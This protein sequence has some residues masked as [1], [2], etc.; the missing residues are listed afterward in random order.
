MYKTVV[1][2]PNDIMSD[3]ICDNY[4]MLLVLNRFGIN[5]G[6][7]DAT[8][9]K[10]CADN[11]IDLTTF[12]AVVNLLVSDKNATPFDLK[13]LSIISLI[14]YLHNSHSYFLEFKL[15]EIRQKL[16]EAIDRKDNAVAIAIINYYDE[17][18]TEVKKHMQY[19]EERVFP[20]VKDLL[21]GKIVDKYNINIFS[22]HHDAIEFKL[23]ELKDIIIKY[24]P[25]KASYKLSS[26]LFDI[27][28][29]EK[30]LASHNYIEDHLMVPAIK[31]L[32]N[33]NKN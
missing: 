25:T 3:L 30:D 14:E 7:G 9:E 31:D 29:C 8:I 6:F 20:Y 18:T 21:S 33:L 13:G 5:L 19:E 24:Y 22:E 28:S 32:E 17:Y 16:I 2:T 15:P 23:S 10:V 27:F 26:V 12:L 4:P 1:Y 11:N